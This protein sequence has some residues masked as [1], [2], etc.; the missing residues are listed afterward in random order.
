[1]RYRSGAADAFDSTYP[2]DDIKQPTPSPYSSYPTGGEQP[3]A[4]VPY[5]QQ[6][7]PFSNP[8]DRTAP[9]IGTSDFSQ[10]PTY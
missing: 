10:P 5:Q 3:G 8:E 7:Q 1:M 6:Q 2:G 4:E 9:G